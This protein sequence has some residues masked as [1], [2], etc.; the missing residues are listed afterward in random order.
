MVKDGVAVSVVVNPVDAELEL[1]SSTQ[2]PNNTVVLTPSGGTTA[3]KTVE[4]WAKSD[5]KADAGKE[6]LKFTTTSSE[7]RL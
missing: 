3:T 6:T 2:A 1:N 7:L 5:G 4:V